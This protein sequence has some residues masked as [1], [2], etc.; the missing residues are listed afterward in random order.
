ME[1]CKCNCKILKSQENGVSAFREKTLRLSNGNLA[2][3]NKDFINSRQRA[4]LL[5]FIKKNGGQM[6]EERELMRVRMK[7]DKM[8]D[9]RVGDSLDLSSDTSSYSEE[10][11]LIGSEMEGQGFFQFNQPTGLT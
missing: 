3:Q 2:V 8:V 9:K 5:N 7:E 1:N 6:G 10:E 4:P 11:S